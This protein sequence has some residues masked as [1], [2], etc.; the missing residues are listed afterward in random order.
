[1]DTVYISH[2][3]PM[4]AL[5]DCPARDFLMNWREV[6]PEKPK[7]VL[8]I[9]AHWTTMEPSVS[10]S[11]YNSTIHDFYG[12]PPALYK[13]KYNAPGAP[14]LAKRVKMLLRTAGFHLIQE[15][16]SRG[17]D[18]GAWVP[19]ILMYPEVDIPVCQLSVQPYR[20]AQHHYDLGRALAPLREEGILIMASGSATHNLRTLD[21]GSNSPPSWAVA[22]DNWLNECLMNGRFDDVIQYEKKAPHATKAHPTPEH[23]LPLLVALGAAGDGAKARRIHTSWAG[24][25]LSMASFVFTP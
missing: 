3:S 24:S 19:L 14:D 23:F 18:H 1:M 9:S 6:L 7:A 10:S 13:L 8:A 12:F 25:T 15:D 4:L 20:D 22:F 2:G 17:L 11:L 5:D 16:S 21:F